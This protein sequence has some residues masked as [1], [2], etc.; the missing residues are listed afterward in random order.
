MIHF[1]L[2]LKRWQRVVV[3]VLFIACIMLLFFVGNKKD[4]NLTIYTDTTPITIEL[5]DKKTVI[6]QKITTMTLEKKEYTY[7]VSKKNTPQKFT[8]YL[9]LSS[10]KSLSIEV[11]Y[12]IFTRESVLSSLCEASDLCYKKDPTISV[13]FFENYTW[14]VVYKNNTHIVAILKREAKYWNI[15][16]IMEDGGGFES[17]SLPQSIEREIIKSEQ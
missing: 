2:S 10:E 6:N 14:A 12:A 7:E 11:N 4:P 8:G 5:N 1:L 3:A 17:G 16:T 9:D 13:G 15:H